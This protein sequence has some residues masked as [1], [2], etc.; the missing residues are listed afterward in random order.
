E[1]LLIQANRQQIGWRLL[2]P[3]R[4]LL[5][6]NFKNGTAPTATLLRHDPPGRS[7]PRVGNVYPAARGGV[8]CEESVGSHHDARSVARIDPTPSPCAHEP[9]GDDQDCPVA[10]LRSAGC[11]ADR[12]GASL[13]PW[14]RAKA[15]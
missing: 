9:E 2:D 4:H 13:H 11:T 8:R 7:A 15:G 5:S 6:P 1:K 3:P 14:E 12:K 10:G